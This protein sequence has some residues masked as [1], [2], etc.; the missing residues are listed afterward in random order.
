MQSQL[1]FEDIQDHVLR[2]LENAVY[3]I[4]IA[5]PVLTHTDILEL[6]SNKSLQNVKVELLL[7]N[8][9]AN[10]RSGMQ[11]DTLQSN[12]AIIAYS[13]LATVQ[14]RGSFCIIDGEVVLTGISS[15]T[16]TLSE[17]GQ[18]L[19]VLRNAPEV[20]VQFLSAFKDVFLRWQTA[21]PKQSLDRIKLLA[22]LEALR[23]VIQAHDEEDIAQ[24]LQKLKLLP[25]DNEEAGDVSEIIT[26]VDQGR[27]DDAESR[28]SS[29]L[30]SN[31]QV[32]VYVDPECTDLKLELKVLEVQISALESEKHEIERLLNAYQYRHTVEL[33]ELMRQILLLSREILRQEAELYPEKEDEYRQAQQEYDDFESDFMHSTEHEVATLTPEEQQELKAMFRACTKLC[34]PDVVAD[35]NKQEAAEVFN[36]LNQAYE[37]NN[38]QAVKEVYENLQQGSYAAASDTLNDVQKMHRSVVTMRTKLSSLSKE[39]RVL[40]SSE[41]YNEITGISDWDEYFTLLKEQMQDEY[42]RLKRCQDEN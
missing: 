3:S 5:T 14:N 17:Q 32:V 10:I 7:S 21:P 23:G 19:T 20:A 27:L 35:E 11:F 2:E 4:Q 28:I 36:K 24:Q 38:M 42:E 31:K 30:N 13:E 16:D 26:L 34:H 37:C 39:I 29:F 18:E 41:V 25:T 15:W 33:G 12:G 9:K 22:R 1:Y 8:D 40:R 6:I